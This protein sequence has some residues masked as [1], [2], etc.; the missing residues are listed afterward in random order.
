[1]ELD[2]VQLTLELIAHRSESLTSNVAVSRHIAG[3]LERL[4][5]EVEEVAYMNANEVEKLCLVARLGQGQGGLSLMGHSDTV[6]ARRADGWSGDPFT[7]R[8]RRGRLYG[9]GACDMK[10][11]LAACLCAAARFAGREL[12]APLYIVVTADEEIQARG[13]R[14]VVAR[15]PLF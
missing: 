3:I 7:G 14:E 1:M 11:P 8:V 4:G 6:P 15:S 12:V 5:F 10:G 2:V 13:A 9:R